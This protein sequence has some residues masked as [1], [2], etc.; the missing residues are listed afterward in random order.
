MTIYE[1]LNTC[2]VRVSLEEKMLHAF[3][4]LSEPIH[5]ALHT[6][7]AVAVGMIHDPSVGTKL[8]TTDQ[9]S[10]LMRLLDTA[11][12]K[13]QIDMALSEEQLDL[14]KA[15]IEESRRP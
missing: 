14:A 11:V 9:Y 3:K 7:D 6:R 15:I 10:Q 5:W 2:P 1:L 4:Q 12:T 13:L 8:L